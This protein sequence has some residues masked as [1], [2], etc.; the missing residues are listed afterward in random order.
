M[1]LL[2]IFRDTAANFYTRFPS[3]PI[4][5]LPVEDAVAAVASTVVTTEGLQAVHRTVITLN[6]LAVS[7]S[8]TNV[9]GGSKIYTFPEGLI[10]IYGA[11]A[12]GITPTTTSALASTLNASKTLSTG[13]GSVQT[14][15]QASGTL[16]TTEQ[17]IV[18]A[19]STTSSA[20]VNVA[21]TGGNGKCPAAPVLLD[22]TTTA[23]DLFLNFGV[24]TATDIDGDATITVDGVVIVL[25]SHI[26]DY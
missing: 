24:P 16:A 2:K 6:D 4:N 22:G 20:T 26:V 7:L 23:A 15:T 9:G 21:G 14:T 3:L 8:D 11:A 13:V 10:R 5:V 19:F 17:D 1:A 18:N 12:K 25:W